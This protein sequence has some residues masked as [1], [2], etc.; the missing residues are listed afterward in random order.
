MKV[1][2]TGATGFV[3][4]R[5]LADMERGG[6]LPVV[7]AVRTADEVPDLPAGVRGA[8]VGSIGEKTD[9]TPHLDGVDTVV[10]LAAHVH[11]GDEAQGEH[12][13]YFQVNTR[14]TERLVRE[15]AA[16]G[17]RKFIFLSTVKVMGE[18]QEEGYSLSDTPA[19]VGPYAVSKLEAENLLRDRCRDG[20][21]DLAIIRPPLVYGPG[22]K[23]NFLRLMEL[24][25]RHAPLPLG[26]IR[27]RRSLVFVG[28][29]SS[30]ILHFLKQEKIQETTVFATDG[31]PVSTS[32]LFRA[33]SRQLEKRCFVWS[34]PTGL[35]RFLTTLLGKQA[36]FQRL[37][38]SLWVQDH[39]VPG[40]TRPFT[41]AEGLKETVSWFNRR[42]IC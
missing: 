18:G 14:G 8:V 7:A 39:S 40:W 24:A 2:V 21:I 35:M 4:T 41:F 23:A 31:D 28:N 10:H 15:A 42:T 27:N 5:L 25:V 36:A 33:L 22:V 6:M 26:G 3:G 19:P 1:L 16:A 32:Q 13:V 9:W 12:S 38:G 20:Q 30:L 17:V 29:L 37:T 11:S 34:F